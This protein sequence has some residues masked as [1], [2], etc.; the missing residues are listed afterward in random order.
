MSANPF[1]TPVY[2][3]KAA[4]M[5]FEKLNLSQTWHDRLSSGNDMIVAIAASSKTEMSGTG[6]TT[7]GLQL[8]RKFD[9]SP[10]PFDATEQATLSSEDVADTLY[11]N[12][13][14]RSA[15]LFDEAQGTAQSDGIDNRRAMADAVVKMSRAAATYRYKQ[16][17]LIIIAQSTRWIDSRMMDIIDRLILIQ[18]TDQDKGYGRAIVFDHYFDDL[19]SD[20]QEYTPAI[21]DIYWRPLPDD[22]P[23]YIAMHEMKQAAGD[24]HSGEDDE[25]EGEVATKTEEQQ[26]QDAKLFHD[27]F[28][29]AW[30]KVGD[31]PGMEKSGEWY[32][33]EIKDREGDE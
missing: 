5:D 23:D 30:R 22:D 6:K 19:S 9:A 4:V 33:Q 10:S 17:P 8:C 20:K 31:F 21:E 11:P 7:L 16:H 13:E 24:P 1:A 32:R 25:G 14:P 28:G 15:I 27:E 26:I 3:R 2:D 29:V 18:E 12:L